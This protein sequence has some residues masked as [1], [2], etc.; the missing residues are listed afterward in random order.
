MKKN[1]KPTNIRLI[2][3]VRRRKS[4][5]AQTFSDLGITTYEGC[6][7]M[8][9]SMGV[10]PPDERDFDRALG[11]NRQPV[12]DPQEGVIVVDTPVIVSESTG[13]PIPQE[14]F[15]DVPAQLTTTKRYKRRPASVD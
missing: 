8:C 6:L 9:A 10:E 4:T 7:N 1:A 11:R 12:N 13:N 5:L 14:P 2:D 15:E 3:L